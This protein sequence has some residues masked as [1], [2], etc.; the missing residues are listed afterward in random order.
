MGHSDKFISVNN[1]H[2]RKDPQ[3]RFFCVLKGGTKVSLESAESQVPSTQNNLH[4]N[5]AHSSEGLS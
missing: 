4:V 2:S 5:V 3:F 1:I